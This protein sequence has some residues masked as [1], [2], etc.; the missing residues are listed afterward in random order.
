MTCEAKRSYCCPYGSTEKWMTCSTLF[1]IGFYSRYS[2]IGAASESPF[3]S[4]TDRRVGASTDPG[5]LLM[6]LFPVPTQNQTARTVASYSWLKS[7]AYSWVHI[8]GHVLRAAVRAQRL[9]RSEER[10][11]QE[12]RRA[13]M[14]RTRR[15]LAMGRR[16]R[17]EPKSGEQKRASLGTCRF[18][19]HGITCVSFQWEDL[20]RMN[21]IRL[22][23]HT[24]CFM[25]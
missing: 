2:P 13:P 20:I 10:F 18:G 16:R 7:E 9:L 8:W 17:G 14:S 4:P 23:I 25:I 5:Q 24:W 11:L 19:G 21:A 22:M 12:L 15:T 3:G 1:A 6:A